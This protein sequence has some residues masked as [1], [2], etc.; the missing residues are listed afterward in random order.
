METYKSRDP[1][2]ESSSQRPRRAV[3]VDPVQK[4]A[5]WLNTQ[6][7]LMLQFKTEGRKTPMS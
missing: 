3:G 2:G 1:Q 7:E 6:I 4:P 5:S